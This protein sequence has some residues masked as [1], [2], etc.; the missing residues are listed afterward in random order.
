VLAALRGEP[1]AKGIES[2]ARRAAE[3]GQGDPARARARVARAR[4]SLEPLRE[5]LA[6]LDSLAVD[7]SSSP[8][9]EW[10]AWIAQLRRVFAAAD[11]SCGRLAAHLAEPDD[12]EARRWFG[13]DRGTGAR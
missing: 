11:L 5:S 8:S 2:L 13:R 4:V 10:D 3:A 12:A 6:A 7:V 9:P 1:L